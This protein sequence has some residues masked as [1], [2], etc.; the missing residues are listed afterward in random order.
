MSRVYYRSPICT[1]NWVDNRTPFT[2]WYACMNPVLTLALGKKGEEQA[3]Q[4]LRSLGHICYGRNVRMGH[5]EID[6]ISFDQAS[7]V[8]VFTEVKT[9]KTLSE[10]FSAWSSMTRRKRRAL[11]RAARLWVTEHAFR[12]AYRIDL[13]F[14]EAGTITE[15]IEEIEWLD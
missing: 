8:L 4:Y 2:V 14:I 6:I 3:W 9:R 1:A 10:H 11:Q 12:G 13:I 5:D 7:S 15:H